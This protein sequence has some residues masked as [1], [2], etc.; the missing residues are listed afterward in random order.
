[1]KLWSGK[2][3][4]YCFYILGDILKDGCLCRIFFYELCNIGR[5]AKI[6]TESYKQDKVL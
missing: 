5:K 4:C 6:P 3:N 2:E 1:M